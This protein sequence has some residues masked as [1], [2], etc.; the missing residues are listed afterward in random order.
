MRRNGDVIKLEMANFMEEGPYWEANSY[1]SLKINFHIYKS[2]P[3][4]PILSHINQFHILTSHFFKV[5]FIIL[6]STLRSL[7]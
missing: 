1:G 6:P 7:K 5:H 4:D 2:S 3:L